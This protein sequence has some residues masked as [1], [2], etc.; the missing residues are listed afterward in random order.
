MIFLESLISEG[1]PA[2]TF[3]VAN[4][5]GYEGWYKETLKEFIDM[6]FVPV[7][8]GDGVI[9]R[10]KGLKVISGDDIVA[11][12]ANI[13]RDK[14]K[15]VIFCVD[16]DGIYTDDPKTVPSAKLLKEISREEFLRFAKRGSDFSGGMMKKAQS[17][18]KIPPQIPIYIINGLKPENILK[19]FEGENPG[20]LIS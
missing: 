16:V 17:I 6:G 12:I 15:G 13:L 19:V 1:I 3:G 5:K 9:D 11:E 8:H 14:I 2:V 20:T 10:E 7:L 18:L 4:I